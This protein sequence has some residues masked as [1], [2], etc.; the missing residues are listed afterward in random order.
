[1]NNT[2]ILI[3]FIFFMSCCGI[4][5]KQIVH[6]L[7]KQQ[8]IFDHI[9]T[10]KPRSLSLIGRAD[11]K[12]YERQMSLNVNIYNIIDSVIYVSA[13]GPFY[14]ELFRAKITP[15]SIL[16][17]NRV[18]KTYFQQPISYIKNYTQNKISFYDVQQIIN[19]QPELDG[20]KYKVKSS[21]RGFELLDK[22]KS[23]MLDKSF[24]IINKKIFT[25]SNCL[26]IMFEEYGEN[27]HIA[28]KI[29]VSTCA[30]EAFDLTIHY[31]QVDFN[32]QS[33]FRIE[34]PDSFDE[35]N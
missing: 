19:G 26:N 2:P 5:N 6:N 11:I 29:K 25:E 23:L 12:A 32:K 4:Q 27:D 34:I 35:I 13:R 24:K 17:L 20:K 28:R 9:K 3:C 31:S 16:V 30:R 7:N 18:N 21:N 1:M 8:I 33:G 14:L 15:D 10:K 22:N